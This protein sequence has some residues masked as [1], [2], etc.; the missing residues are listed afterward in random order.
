MALTSSRYG[1]FIEFATKTVAERT[2][3]GSRNT[4]EE[5]VGEVNAYHTAQGFCVVIVTD[6]AYQRM[7]AQAFL[8][9]VA[10]AFKSNFTPTEINQKAPGT[11]TWPQIKLLRQEA[12]KAES[13]GIAAVQKELD[14]TKVVLHKTIESVLERG[15]KLDSLV[16]KSDE[17]SGQS[18]MFYKTA[19]QQNSCCVVM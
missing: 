19:K 8:T 14:E 12:T 10:D 3:V 4:V 7:T 5:K 1:E 11:F 13:S 2:K 9:K 16:A 15:E 6:P 17:L 18:K